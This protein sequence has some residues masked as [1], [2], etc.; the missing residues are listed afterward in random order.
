[1]I[2]SPKLVLAYVATWLVP[3]SVEAAVLANLN[4]MSADLTNHALI[5]E[6]GELYGGQHGLELCLF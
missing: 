1:M 4:W 5:A 2:C 6:F 3:A